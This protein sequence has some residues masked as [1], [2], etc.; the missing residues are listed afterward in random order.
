[1]NDGAL[2]PVTGSVALGIELALLAL[3][4]RERRFVI[5]AETEVQGQLRTNGPVVLEVE[6]MSPPSRQPVGQRDV[7][8]CADNGTQQERGEIVA[9]G[10]AGTENQCRRTGTRRKAA[11]AARELPRVRI[12]FVAVFRL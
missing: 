10:S 2:L 1:M 9:G 3:L 12:S 6:G 8:V 5:P 7:E 11:T 4:G